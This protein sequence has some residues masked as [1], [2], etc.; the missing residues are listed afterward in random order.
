MQTSINTHLVGPRQQDG[1]RPPGSGG[2]R[3]SPGSKRSSGRTSSRRGLA[4][5]EHGAYAQVSIPLVFGLILAGPSVAG[6]AWAI[7]VVAG[8]LA[9]EPVLVLLGQ[10]GKRA[11]R[12]LASAARRRLTVLGVVGVAAAAV[13]FSSAPIRAQQGMLGCMLLALP[14]SV[15]MA[16]RMEKTLAGESLASLV[17]A[18]AL[19]P[20]LLAGDR[21]VTS[22]LQAA[23]VLSAIFLLGTLM[24]RSVIQHLRNGRVALAT[25]GVGL[26]I[27]TGG[28]VAALQAGVIA[29]QTAMAVAPTALV[30]LALLIR[31]PHPRHLRRLG[32]VLLA[33]S[34]LG[35]LILLRSLW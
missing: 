27:V 18:S 23:A 7:L 15:L 10:R 30:S 3:L 34:I 26:L 6:I 24:V 20:I 33:A 5:R 25:P 16:K 35:S 28:A 9:H 8:F 29:W 22:A 19:V 12:N 31:T 4:P 1:S 32:F 13:A 2:G 14:L 17:F 21:D 11:R